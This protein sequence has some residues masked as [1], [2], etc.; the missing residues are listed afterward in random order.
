MP[1]MSGQSFF[2]EILK[3][4]EDVRVIISSGQNSEE[5]KD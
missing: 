1:R 5:I 3:V 4:K 2:E